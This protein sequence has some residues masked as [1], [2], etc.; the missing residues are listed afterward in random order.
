MTRQWIRKV[1]LTVG[2][3]SSSIDLSNMRVRF[4]VEQFTV[5]TP[6]TARIFVTNLSDQTANKIEKEYTTVTLNGGYENGDIATIFKGEIFQKRIGHET[7]TDSYLAILATESQEAYSY[8]VISK[9]LAAGHTF[10]DQVDACLE[11]LKPYGITAGHDRGSWVGQ[12]A[13][14]EVSLLARF[15]ISCV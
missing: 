8:G 4:T 15:E 3:G 2:S 11:A 14:W 5:Q 6:G 1:N 10:R 7:Q 12:N 9:S 13:D